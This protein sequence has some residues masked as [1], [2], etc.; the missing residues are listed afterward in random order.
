MPKV[1]AGTTALKNVK[2]QVCSQ[3]HY[4]NRKI[5]IDFS[6]LH[7]LPKV[8]LEPNSQSHCQCTHTELHSQPC[9]P[10]QEQSAQ[11]IA[12]GSKI[13]TARVES[14]TRGMSRA[15]M[16]TL[17][18]CHMDCT[19]WVV[20]V[21]R[22]FLKSGVRICTSTSLNFQ[23]GWAAAAILQQMLCFENIGQCCPASFGGKKVWS[24]HRKREDKDVSPGGTGVF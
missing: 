24:I 9:S 21:V 12:W 3:A 13:K 2:V 14:K 23:E 20:K 18:T 5:P 16:W 17:E 8:G 7:S 1:H 15:S 22:V 4:T 6:G 11:E 19:R 10:K